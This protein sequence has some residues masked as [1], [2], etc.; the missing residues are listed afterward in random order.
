MCRAITNITTVTSLKIRKGS[1]YHHFRARDSQA[2]AFKTR[3]WLEAQLD[4][5]FDGKTLIVTH[6]APS[7]RSMVFPEKHTDLN[8]APQVVATQVKEK[9]GELRF[10]V[11]AADKYQHG[12]IAFATAMSAQLCEKCGHPGKRFKRDGWLVTRCE[13]HASRESDSVDEPSQ[14]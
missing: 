9:Y 1:S 14:P 4:T 8:G 10:Y 11:Q 13:K 3:D 6:H 12:M 7:E 5:P 2:E